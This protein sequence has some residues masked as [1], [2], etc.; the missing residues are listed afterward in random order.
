MNNYLVKDLMVPISEYATVQKGSTLFEAV[1][2]L[3]KAQGEFENSVYKHRA[4]LVL[5]SKGQVIGKLSQMNVLRAIEPQNKFTD[6]IAEIEKFGFSHKFISAVSH[7]FRPKDLSIEEL[8]KMAAKKKVEDFMK[9]PSEGEYV[10]EDATLETAI[11]QIVIGR[12]L[13]LLV[14]RGKDI[15]GIL[16]MSDVFGSIFHIMKIGEIKELNPAKEK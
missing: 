1:Q 12:L 10:H 15:V 16:R 2:A 5:N 7:K 6:K 8:Y 4:I 13:S 3:E 9:T 14:T 11:N